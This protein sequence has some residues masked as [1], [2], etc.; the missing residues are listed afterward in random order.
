MSFEHHKR[1]IGLLVLVSS[2]WVMWLWSNNSGLKIQLSGFLLSLFF[3]ML[4]YKNPWKWISPFL[5]RPA[6]CWSSDFS[7]VRISARS[8]MHLSC[9]SQ[10]CSFSSLQREKER[11]WRKH[12]N[13]RKLFLASCII[14]L[15]FMSLVWEIGGTNK[16]SSLY[17]WQPDSHSPYSKVCFYWCSFCSSLL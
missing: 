2:C 3:S 11:F 1:D 9:I 14:A 4:F 7:L 6:C 8:L 10:R 15:I 5:N 16:S 17:L 13:I 12:V